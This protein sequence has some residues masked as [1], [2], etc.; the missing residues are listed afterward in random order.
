MG[1][2]FGVDC[3]FYGFVVFFVWG[4]GGLVVMGMVGEV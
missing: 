3:V 2:W 1:M 4:R